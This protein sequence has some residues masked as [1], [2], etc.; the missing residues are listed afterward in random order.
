MITIEHAYALALWSVIMFGA[1][2]FVGIYING[3]SYWV[4]PDEGDEV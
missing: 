4:G 2:I 1:G 3:L